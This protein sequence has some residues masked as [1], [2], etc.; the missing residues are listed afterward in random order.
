MPD[1]DNIIKAI[2]TMRDQN[3]KVVCYDFKGDYGSRFFNP[4]RD[5]IFN[6][7]D[8]R[9]VKWRLMRE[10]TSYMDID[11][12]ATSLIPDA[13]QADSFWNNGARDVFAGMLHYLHQTGQRTNGDIWNMVTRDVAEVADILKKTKGGERGY[14]YIQDPNDKMALSVFAV[15]MQYVKS[16]EFTSA[17]DDD[18]ED[19]DR[20]DDFSIQHWLDNPRGGFLFITNYADCQ[21]TLRPVLSLLVDLIGRRLLSMSENKRRRVFFLLDEFGTLQKLSTIVRLLTLSRSK[22][23]SVWLGIQD[24]GQLEKIYGKDLRQALVNSCGSNMILQVQDPN[25]AEFL[26]D[27]L[28]DQEVIETRRTFTMGLGN[29]RDGYS[30]VEEKKIQRLVLK[31]QLMRDLKKYE[32]YVSLSDQQ[33][34]KTKT[35]NMD[36]LPFICEPFMLRPD[37]NLDNILEDQKRLQDKAK[38]LVEEAKREKDLMDAIKNDVEKVQPVQR[39]ENAN[40]KDVDVE[41]DVERQRSIRDRQLQEDIN[42]GSMDLNK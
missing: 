10:L 9:C 34:V 12:L 40:K 27:K 38:A 41:Q 11:S 1:M 30:L 15:M 5:V 33:V 4:R 13:S 18:C 7:L 14:V 3:I 37:L 32:Q 16:F 21:D 8:I 28:G 22:G 23:G 24:V 20:G 31:S 35:S 19:G 25:T 26:S 39:E 29:N 17:I 42:S 6:P 2:D 36:H